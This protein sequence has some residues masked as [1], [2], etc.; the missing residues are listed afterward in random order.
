MNDTES[1]AVDIAEF[2]RCTERLT[3]QI[4]EASAQMRASRATLERSAELAEQLEAV[5]SKIQEEVAKAEKAWS[6]GE[7]VAR[8]AAAEAYSAAFRGIEVAS[9]TLI[10]E[11]S[12]ATA[13]AKASMQEF[14]RVPRLAKRYVMVVATAFFILALICAYSTARLIES[15]KSVSVQEKVN[16]VYFTHLWK[17]ANLEEQR[18]IQAV[19]LRAPMDPIV[20]KH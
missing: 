6:N 19:M 16:A 12:A 4:D 11:C 1:K 9:Q 7:E 2:R 5:G 15:A 14:Q 10:S 20:L 3:V 13:A 8:R 17:N 18:V